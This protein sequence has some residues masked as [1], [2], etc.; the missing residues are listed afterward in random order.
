MHTGLIMQGL[1]SLNK[2][3]SEKIW[4]TYKIK[5]QQENKMLE[6]GISVEGDKIW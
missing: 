5:E 1:E 6:E 4:V 2:G 3:I